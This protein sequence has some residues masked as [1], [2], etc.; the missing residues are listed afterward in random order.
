MNKQLLDC[1]FCGLPTA[2]MRDYAGIR[3]SLC[4][5]CDAYVTRI[6]RKQRVR[7]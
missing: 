2:T 4:A 5:K 6:S 3:V 7:A 1:Y